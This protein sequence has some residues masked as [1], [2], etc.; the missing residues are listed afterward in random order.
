MILNCGSIVV[1]PT[2]QTFIF[3]KN[4]AS[5]LYYGTDSKSSQKYIHVCSVGGTT[6]EPQF[7]IMIKTQLKYIHDKL[8]KMYES[9][10]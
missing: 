3:L 7:K 5:L 6:I 1:T 8:K 4:K 2:L 10:K 9:V